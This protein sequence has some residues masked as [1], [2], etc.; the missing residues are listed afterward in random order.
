MAPTPTKRIHKEVKPL[1]KIPNL[2]HPTLHIQHP[3]VSQSTSSY[4]HSLKK[5]TFNVTRSIFRR[6]RQRPPL[7]TS[8][9]EPSFILSKLSQ[10][11]QEQTGICLNENSIYSRG[12]V[13][14]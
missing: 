4:L 13:Q 11:G 8:A 1:Q 9:V 10:M 12:R 5:A 14:L 7:H 3:R 2:F 6:G